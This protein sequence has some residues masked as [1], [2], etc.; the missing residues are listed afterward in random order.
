M[1]VT[2]LAGFVFW[3]ICARLYSQEQV[4]YATALISALGLAVSLANLGLS[5]TIIRFFH[6][7]TTREADLATKLAIILASSTVVGIVMS[8]LL[9]SMGVTNPTLW[10]GLIFTAA[11]VVA[12]VK[13][14]FDN[15]FIALKASSG[16]LTT[17]VV[18]SGLKL[19]LPFLLVGWGFVGIFA[20]HAIGLV[21]GIIVAIIVLAKRHQIQTAARLHADSMRGK[22][23]FAFGTYSA[24]LIGGLPNNLLPLIVVG[25]LGAATGALWY[26]AMLITNFLLTISSSINQAMFAEISSSK[27]GIGSFIKKAAFGMY[28]L[29]I[30]IAVLVIIFAPFVLGLFSPEYREATEVLRILAIGAIVG[31][32]NY[33]TGS[34]LSLYKKVGFLTLVNGVNAVVV[35]TYAYLFAADITGIA[36]GW[37]LGEIANI[38]LFSAGALYFYKKE[39]S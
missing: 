31:I 21:A 3:A 14:I 18:F 32:A 26:T 16:A 8:F 22:W 10:T 28:G 30:P 38:L 33:I 13:M 15:V 37:I 20:A 11:A 7:S 23:R 27:V 19:V 25:K 24:D 12:S 35:I 2:A 4:G 5:R 36:Y 6:D 39:N 29:V 1:G 17:N 9:D 34:I